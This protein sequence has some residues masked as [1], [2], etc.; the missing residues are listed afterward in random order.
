[1]CNIHKIMRKE[2][3]N[4]RERQAYFAERYYREHELSEEDAEL[5]LLI[6]KLPVELVKFKLKER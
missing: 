5:M 2:D 6:R 3:Q 4:E 1:M